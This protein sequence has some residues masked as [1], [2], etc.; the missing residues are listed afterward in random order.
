[1]LQIQRK[2][3]AGRNCLLVGIAFE[4]IRCGRGVIK[5]FSNTWIPD[6]PTFVAAPKSNLARYGILTHGSD[7]ASAALRPLK[8]L[9]LKDLAGNKPKNNPKIEANLLIYKY[10][11]YKSLFLKDLVGEIP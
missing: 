4:I 5:M 1:M 9:F 8:Y 6:L 7:P 2:G 3:P 10:F 11:T